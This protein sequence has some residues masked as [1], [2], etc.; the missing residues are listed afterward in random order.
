MPRQYRHPA[1]PELRALAV[2]VMHHHRLGLRPR[3]GE[4]VDLVVHLEIGANFRKRHR[5]FL[6]LYSSRMPAARMTFPIR[7]ISSLIAAARTS[8]VLP[9]GSTPKARNF[10]R[11]SDRPR[12]RTVSW[13]SRAMMA[14]GV[15]A[16]ANSAYSDATSKLGSPA[17]AMVGTP[18]SS[19]LG[20]AVVTASARRRPVFTCGMTGGA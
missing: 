16:G 14:A 6:S 10:S 11:T 17:L 3:V 5:R 13:F 8:G 9:M 2:A 15:R 1:V 20:C 4:I 12:K 19:T 7:V 18:G